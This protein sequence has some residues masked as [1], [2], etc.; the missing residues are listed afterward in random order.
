MYGGTGLGLTISRMLVEMMG[1]H[2]QVK[3]ELGK[4]S[5]FHFTVRLKR[6]KEHA[7]AAEAGVAAE[8]VLPGVRILVVDD[9]PTNRRIL[10]GLLRNWGMKPTLA[11][12]GQS[13]LAAVQE[14]LENGRPFQLILTD[15]LMPGM[16]GI[17]LIESIRKKNKSVLGTIMMLTSSGHHEDA[18]RCEELGIAAYLLKP[19]RQAELRKAIARVLGAVADHAHPSILTKE[20]LES[21]K[22]NVSLSVLLAEDNAVNQ[23]L[24][25]ALLEKRGHKVT[26]VGNGREALQALEQTHFDIVLMDMQMPEM[27]GIEATKAIRAR[28]ERSGGR[29]PVIAMT[30]LAMKGD[31]ER[32]IGAGMDDYLTKPL[33]AIE[34]DAILE[35]YSIRKTHDSLTSELSPQDTA[36]PD[37]GIIDAGELLERIGNDRAFLAELVALFYEDHPGQLE[38]IAKGLA[39][40]NANEVTRGAHSLKGALANLAAPTASALAAQL[41]QQSAS[42]NLQEAAITFEAFKTELKRVLDAL[43]A[44]TQE[45]AR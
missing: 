35:K 9:N 13:A 17:E 24:A 39:R 33:R 22:V 36:V 1:G 41:E 8:H 10:E 40:Q 5:E 28:E 15:M 23:K 12:D 31:R 27:D 16:D 37:S 44:L 18:S 3:S 14:S 34:L 2:I 45:T 32:G 43:H 7:P 29:Q 38:Q 6:G 4:G 19:I 26:V 21:H 30:A 11:P 25:K 20:T 42:G